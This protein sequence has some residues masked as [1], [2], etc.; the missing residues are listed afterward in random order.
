MKNSIERILVLIVALLSLTG[1]EEYLE[2]DPR[3]VLAPESFFNSDQ[4]ARAAAN[5]LYVPLYS[6][7]VYGSYGISRFYM[8]GADVIEPSREG[9]GALNDINNYT[10]SEGRDAGA[11]E[12]W[13]E[14]YKIIQDANI[15]IDRVSGNENISQAAR[16]QYLGEALFLRS[17]AYY[18]LTNMFG[19]VPYYRDNLSIEEVRSLGRH[20]KEQIR[21]DLVMDLQQAQEL[22][23][24][25]NHSEN[26]ASKWAA[27]TLMVK[28]HLIQE[29]WE[30]AR[31]K[32]IEIIEDSP[33]RLL[34]DYAAIFDP[35]NPYN[36]EI[37]WSVNFVKDLNPTI[38]T[39]LFT[40]RIRDEPKNSEEKQALQEALAARDE[41]FTGYGLA[42]PKCGFVDE[43]PTDDLRRPV[44]IAEEYLG[45][46]LNYPYMPKMW[47]LDQ[48]NSPR[49]NH[50]ENYIVFRLADVYLMAAEAENELNGPAGA[51]QYI[52]RVRE[53]AYEPDQPL[54]GL[55]REEFRQ[56]IHD[57]RKWELA[58]E[59][60]RRMD[61]IRWGILLEVV[62]NTRH[63]AY[64]PAG[65]IQPHHVLFPVPEEELEL[66]PNL[67]E[68]D[69]TNNGYR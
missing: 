7:A 67:L 24:A 59:G 49:Q 15:L 33:H 27:A 47:N 46:E 26:R 4:E 61:L 58:G 45:F 22:I 19:D 62:K 53:R 66:N 56:A 16:D 13:I 54:S 37:I 18:H 12:A 40:P 28:I 20:N 38:T 50:G 35:A 3:D 42:I 63:C 8:Y 1:C 52:N 65:N 14:F 32:A 36:D 48:I 21:N 68:S 17:F 34:D 29:N 31:D 43:F 5:G 51:Y 10:L 2:E 60:H 69:P 39:D 25:G 57:E 11:R 30:E 41:G 9:G 55:S 44:N 6:G 23:P 64:D